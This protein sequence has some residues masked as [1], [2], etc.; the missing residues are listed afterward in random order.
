MKACWLYEEGTFAC[1]SQN[2]ATRGEKHWRPTLLH[3]ADEGLV[4]SCG[5]RLRQ[6]RCS[7]RRFSGVRDG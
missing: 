5:R 2:D 4:R 6:G 1:L 3:P 7:P